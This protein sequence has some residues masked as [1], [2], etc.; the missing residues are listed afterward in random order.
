MNRTVLKI[1]LAILIILLGIT[2]FYT[3]F[4][5]NIRNN[6]TAEQIANEIKEKNSNVG[7]IVTYTETTDPNNLLGKEGQY[8]SKIIFED[9]RLEQFEDGEP[10]GG[11][12]E[13]FKNKKDMKKRKE[14]LEPFASSSGMLAEYMYN[15]NN[16][17]IR[18]NK[19]LTP[20]QAKEYEEL[21]KQITK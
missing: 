9:V 11:T 10:V 6:L 19:K 21:F 7:K 8:I 13:V 16:A 14:Y 2:V 4:I 3:I 1:V 18:L 17:I 5:S 15:T 20:S 12:I